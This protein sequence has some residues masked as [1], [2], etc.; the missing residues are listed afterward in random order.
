MISILNKERLI[1][2]L[3]TTMFISLALDMGGDFGIR[4]I[5]LPI[6]ALLLVSI[7]G[8]SFP[9]IAFLFFGLLVVYP[10]ILLLVGLLS[11]ADLSIATSQIK[12]TVLAFLIYILVFH[13]PY[14]VST[15]AL[16]FSLFLVALLA[17]GLA[18]GLI[19]DFN[20]VTSFLSSMAEMKG[21]YFGA[22]AT[23]Y[24]AT[25]PNVYFKATLFFVPA[26][27]YALFTRNYLIAFVFFTA[28]IA[29]VSK[30]GIIVTGFIA[31][32]YFIFN[33]NVRGAIIVSMLLIAAIVFIYNSPL[34]NLFESVINDSKTVN[35]RQ[36][37]FESLISLWSE[38]PLN[39]LFGF[40][41]GTSFYS[42]GAGNFVSNIEIDHFNVIRKYGLF[43]SLVFF[44]LVLSVAYTAMKNRQAKIR[45][46][47][48]GLL[49]AFIVC[50]TNPVLISP[51]FFL[52]L[53]LTMSANHQSLI[54]GW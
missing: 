1:K 31:M 12:S 44:I 23:G 9:K 8:I 14:E 33:K 3:V 53:F 6:C 50:G 54:R 32:V 26:F 13:I 43:W 27:V 49:F 20:F 52:F 42:S 22:R 47:G 45:G 48:W 2:L 19:F 41:L 18:I 30:T 28:L 24:D 34:F 21:G 5:V 51:L 4:N 7:F 15:K 37:H 17:I 29:A 35:V 38:Y 40:G 39:L 46:M 36:G 10:S 16:L 11:N 25:I